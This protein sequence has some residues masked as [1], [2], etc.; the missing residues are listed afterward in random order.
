MNTSFADLKRSRQSM[1]DKILAETDKVQ[2]GNQGG[3]ADTRSGSQ[4]LIKLVTA[5][6]LFAFFLRQ[7]A[8]IFHGYVCSLMAF[9]D[10]EAGILRTLLRL[11]IKKTLSA[12]IIQRYGI[13]AMKLAR[14]RHVSR[15]VA[16]PISQTSMW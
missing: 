15:S 4:R 14:N 6:L 5:M 12:N 16:Y 2:S 10:Q 7:R 1:Y 9:R 8:R 3:G 13:V 11:S